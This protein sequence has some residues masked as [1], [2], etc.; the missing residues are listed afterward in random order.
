MKIR[1]N[2]KRQ[3]AKAVLSILLMLLPVMHAPS[4]LAETSGANPPGQDANNASSAKPKFIWGVMIVNLFTSQVFGAFFKWAS[5]M[6]SH[7]DAAHPT[8][9]TAVTDPHAARFV[10]LRKDFL[11]VVPKVTDS[12]PVA[13]LT[14]ENGMENYQGA[15]ISLLVLEPDGKSLEVRPISEGF[16]SGEKFRIRIGATFEGDLTIDNIDPHGTRSRLYPAD[17]AAALRIKQGA[18]V[19]LP[20]EK[21]VFFQFDKD[22][23]EEK[24]SFM[25]RDVR[26]DGGSAAQ[27]PIHRQENDMGTGLLQEVQPG[28]YAVIADTISL[29]HR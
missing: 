19:I 16:K 25:L 14:V 29:Q 8:K 20:A 24:L 2:E 26:A 5:S 15:F 21:G 23:G 6:I 13:P 7:G 12:K 4:A 1:L 10:P 22:S 17:A 18:P 3:S 27:S 11:P 28:Q 9:D